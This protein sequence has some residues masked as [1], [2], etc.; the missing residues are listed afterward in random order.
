MRCPST[1]RPRSLA[2]ALL[3]LLS[4]ASARAQAQAAHPAPA[5]ASRAT[6]MA[7]IPL[8]RQARTAQRPQDLLGD[9]PWRRKDAMTVGAFAG[10]VT[11][12]VVGGVIGARRASE[13][14]ESDPTGGAAC[15]T[16]APLQ[17][18]GYALV[19]IVIGAPVGAVVGF[20]VC[21]RR[22]AGCRD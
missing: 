3:L 19:G 9:S 22:S 10:G 8:A 14:A 4:A 5:G 2:A 17:M 15:L 7:S 18:I 6:A 11:G 12:A 21:E 13:C 16:F 20:V 1:R